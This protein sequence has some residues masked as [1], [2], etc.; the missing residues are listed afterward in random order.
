MQNVHVQC[1]M[2]KLTPMKTIKK[3]TLLF[4]K[5][6]F[7]DDVANKMHNWQFIILPLSLI[8]GIRILCTDCLMLTRIS[9]TAVN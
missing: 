1:L 5:K 7:T 9:T 6:K 8:N 2:E 3:N 4:T